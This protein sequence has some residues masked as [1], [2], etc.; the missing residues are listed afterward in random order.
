VQDKGCETIAGDLLAY[1]DESLSSSRREAVARHLEHCADCRGELVWMQSFQR[2]LES[3]GDAMVAHLPVVDVRKHVIAALKHQPAATGPGRLLSF[4]PRK[5][6][7]RFWLGFATAAA[8]IVALW[9]ATAFLQDSRTV[10]QLARTSNESS[11]VTDRQA[12]VPSEPEHLQRFDAERNALGAIATRPTRPDVFEQTEEP[13]TEATVSVADIIQARRE[14]Q[15]MPEALQRL[16]EWARLSAEEARKVAG[17]AD[18][19]LAEEVAAS[20]ALPLDEAIAVLEQAVS[21]YPED[22]TARFALAKA[23]SE[24]DGMEGQALQAWNSLAQLDPSNS[25]PYMEMAAL[26][27]EQGDVENARALLLHAGTLERADV[28]T[29]GSARY[30]RDALVATGMEEDTAS[31]VSALTAGSNEYDYL[32]ALGNSLLAE[33]DYYNAQ[34]QTDVARSIYEAVFGFGEQLESSS[35]YSLTQLAGLDLQRSATQVLEPIYVTMGESEEVQAL[36]QQTADLVAGIDQIGDFFVTLN[37]LFAS[38]LDIVVWGLMAD[39][40]LNEGDL[41]VFDFLKGFF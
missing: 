15:T 4:R 41:G 6:T 39:F 5:E 10:P 28:Y 40:I 38:D 35:D 33:G 30:R 8:I 32:Y 14:A 24:R 17:A 34:G 22:L 36:T 37:D 19:T 29:S 3:H 1:L 18:A 31:L 9:A 26:L 25:T 13:V 16:S 2:R 27:F 7:A 23:Y 20:E 11:P 12:T 21:E